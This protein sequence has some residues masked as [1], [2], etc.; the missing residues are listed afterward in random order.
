MF[1]LSPL[2]LYFISSGQEE[3]SDPEPNK[4]IQIGPQILGYIS[5]A[6]YLGA[7]IPQI[8][9]NHQKKSVHGLSLLFFIFSTFGNLTYAGQILF[10]STEPEYII[11]NL[12]WLLGSLG[13]I[14][15][16]SII[17]LQFFIYKDNSRDG[18]ITE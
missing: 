13:T 14:F 6:L 7:R 3:S 10:Y 12:S 15:E 16:D 1:F 2:L 9:Q 4:P 5:A 18:V 17:F 11:L 8:I